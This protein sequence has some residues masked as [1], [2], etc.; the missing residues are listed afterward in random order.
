M[1]AAGV[2]CCCES[3]VSQTNSRSTT[4]ISHAVQVAPTTKQVRPVKLPTQST[5]FAAPKKSPS[6]ST[7][8]FAAP[9]V[10]PKVVSQTVPHEAVKPTTKTSTK[11]RVPTTPAVK[12]QNA[13]E[14]RLH[15]LQN[16]IPAW[17]GVKDLFYKPSVSD[18]AL[19]D[20]LWLT[21]SKSPTAK[22]LLKQAQAGGM[23]FVVSSLKDATLRGVYSPTENVL[24]VSNSVAKKDPSGAIS[25]AAHESMHGIDDQK[26]FRLRAWEA[27]KPQG[28]QFKFLSIVSET[29]GHS[30]GIVTA[31]EL[32]IVYK[33]GL[34]K[35]TS[36]E[37]ALDYVINDPA[38][39][40]R[41]KFT[42]AEVTPQIRAKLL[43][44]IKSM[45]A[46]QKI[47]MLPFKTNV[48]AI[49]LAAYDNVNVS[50]VD[51]VWDAK[52]TLAKTPPA[53]IARSA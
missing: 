41:L 42:P 51:Q 50:K 24:V 20:K 26:R 25:T 33:G 5:T 10:A 48:K 15:L 32:H 11:P 28:I 7:T 8:A 22:A 17:N 36:M 18:L 16:E 6:T 49:P 53:D 2:G 39:Q 47:G 4:T 34:E 27:L 44:V 37:Q 46:E 21:A 35:L 23:P 14:R 3:K 38:Y 19:R 31:R 30:A 52:S 1:D 43:G 13:Y 29:I 12:L 40:K 45:A 9:K